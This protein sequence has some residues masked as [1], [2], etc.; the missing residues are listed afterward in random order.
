MQT[1]RS[2][3][4]LV[5]KLL[6]I[7]NLLRSVQ[8]DHWAN[9]LSELVSKIESKNNVSIR[10]ISNLFGGM[11]S[12]ND[13]WICQENGHKI[14]GFEVEDINRRLSVMLDEAFLELSNLKEEGL[15]L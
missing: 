9:Q 10:E 3:Q 14:S 7:R 8:E 15:G 13:I 6:N 4:K 12:L 1:P 2:T 5:E 11:G